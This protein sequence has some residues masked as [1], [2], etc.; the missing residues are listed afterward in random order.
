MR[1]T[2][3]HGVLA[4]DDDGHRF[5]GVVMLE[6]VAQADS[7]PSDKVLRSLADLCGASGQ[8]A[9]RQAVVATLLGVQTADVGDMAGMQLAGSSGS[10]APVGEDSDAQYGE[11]CRLGP[12]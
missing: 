10:V 5:A 9:V 2:L 6:G 8:T 11:A 1:D 7:R 12:V 4:A 3:P